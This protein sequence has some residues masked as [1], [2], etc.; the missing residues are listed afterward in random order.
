MS[1][2]KGK[3]VERKIENKPKAVTIAVLK[4]DG[5]ND[6]HIPYKD[7]KIGEEVKIIG[8]SSGRKMYRVYVSASS[9]GKMMGRKFSVSK[10]DNG[11]VVRRLKNPAKV[12]AT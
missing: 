10:T 5:K 9:A 8:D 7:M 11:M 6:L 3:P 12:S 4:F 2:K 1:Q